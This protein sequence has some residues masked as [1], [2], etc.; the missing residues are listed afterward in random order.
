[1]GWRRSLVSRLRK[2]LRLNPSERWT[3]AYAM[4][5]LPLTGMVLRL[6]GLR[7]SQEIFSSFISR[8]SVRKREQSEA[9]L[10]QALHISHL[11]RLANDHGLYQANCLQRS[12]VL[13]WQLR[14]RGIESE[15]HFGTRKDIGRIEAH[16]WVEIKGIVLNDSSDVRQR[17]QPFDRAIA[18]VNAGFR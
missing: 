4:I 18:L 6:V 11:I 5:L 12:L 1:M 16:A 3:L 17:F 8:N 2:F 13:C 10:T 7:R 15:L 14:W 9:V